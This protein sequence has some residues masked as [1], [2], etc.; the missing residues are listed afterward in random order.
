MLCLPLFDY[1][2]QGRFEEGVSDLDHCYNLQTGELADQ[3]SAGVVNTARTQYSSCKGHAYTQDVCDRLVGVS[4][5][6][7]V[8]IASLNDLVR[9]KDLRMLQLEAQPEDNAPVHVPSDAADTDLEKEADEGI[10]VGAE[11]GSQ[12]GNDKKEEGEDDEEARQ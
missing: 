3:V 1:G 9:W 10:D 12:D 5:G 6:H 8:K 7:A 11:E 4:G 2:V